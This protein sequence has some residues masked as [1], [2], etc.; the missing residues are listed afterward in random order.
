MLFSR[1]PYA[2]KWLGL[3]RKLAEHAITCE[4]SPKFPANKGKYREFG[5]TIPPLFDVGNAYHPGA[6]PLTAIRRPELMGVLTG[7]SK[8]HIRESTSLLNAFGRR[9]SNSDGLCQRCQLMFAV[10]VRMAASRSRTCVLSDSYRRQQKRTEEREKALR[11]HRASCGARILPLQDGWMR[12][13]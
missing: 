6:Q 1:L 11:Q 3:Q 13:R 2:A 7:N 10:R 9:E 4:L 5:Q 8:T 12:E